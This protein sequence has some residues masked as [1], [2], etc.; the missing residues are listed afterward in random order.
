[1]TEGTRRREGSDSYSIAAKRRNARYDYGNEKCSRE[2][3]YQ[4]EKRRSL[5]IGHSVI[6][7]GQDTPLNGRNCYPS[8][9]DEFFNIIKCRC[10][11]S[12]PDSFIFLAEVGV[13]GLPSGLTSL[14]C[15]AKE[16]ISRYSLPFKLPGLSAG[17]FFFANS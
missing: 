6:L 17:I 4:K 11:Y 16:M 2:P 9:L 10:F 5:T 15:R 14:A 7:P 13:S 12:P 3:Q 1:M 8:N